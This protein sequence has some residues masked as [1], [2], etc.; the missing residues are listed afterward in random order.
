MRPYPAQ[1]ETAGILFKRRNTARNVVFKTVRRVLDEMC[2]GARRCCYC[3]DSQADEVEHIR[4]KGWYPEFAF[5]WENYLYACGPCNGPKGNKYALFHMRHKRVVHL[6]RA[7]DE[8]VRKPPRGTPLLIDPSIEDP[9]HFLD[10]DLLD[11]FLFLPRRDRPVRDQRRA[12]Y[13]IELLDL[14][15]DPLIRARRLEFGN[16][17]ARLKEYIAEKIVGKPPVKLALL[18]ADLQ[19]LSHP[20]V[21]AEMKRQRASHP[22]LQRLFRQAPEALDW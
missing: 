15:R 7:K 11:T 14:N 18:V 2:S 10:L 13:T 5:T 4:P 9:L 19:R 3:E 12:A 20:T 21:W 1:V 8:P 16:Y 22:E 6:T 17:R